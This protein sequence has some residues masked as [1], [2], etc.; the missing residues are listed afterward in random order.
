MRKIILALA[1]LATIGTASFTTTNQASAG[2]YGHGH[3]YGYSYGHRSY[4]KPYFVKKVYVPVYSSY[5]YGY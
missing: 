5:Y 1:T 2:Y 3:S 4:Y